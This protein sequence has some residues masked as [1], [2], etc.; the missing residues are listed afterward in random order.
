MGCGGAAIRGRFV[1]QDEPWIIT[2]AT[3]KQGMM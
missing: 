1:S 3:A 2:H